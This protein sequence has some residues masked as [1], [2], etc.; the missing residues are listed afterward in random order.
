[1]QHI[2]SFNDIRLQNAWLTIGVYDG[3]HRGHQSIIRPMVEAAHRAKDPAVVLTFWPHP[4]QV[5]GHAPDMKFLT[6]ADERAG[7]WARWGLLTSSP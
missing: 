1:M 7:C 3:V 4:A 2:R 5:L 6:T